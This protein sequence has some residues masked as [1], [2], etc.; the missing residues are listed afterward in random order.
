MPL[1]DSALQRARELAAAAARREPAADAL[2]LAYRPAEAAAVL[3]ISR[4]ML[5]K[6]RRQGLLT[7][8]KIGGALVVTRVQLEAPLASLPDDDVA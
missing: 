8:K 1:T 7:F 4:G 6:L 3:G 2:R 5:Y